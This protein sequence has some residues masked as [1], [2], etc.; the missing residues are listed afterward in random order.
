CVQKLRILIEDSDQNLK[1][2]GLLAMSKI[3]KTHP[4]SV[5]AHKDLVL[6]CLD[7][8]DESIRLRALDLLYGMIS[9]KNLMEIVRKL[10]VNIN[11]SQMGNKYRDELI[12]KIIDICS[13]NDYHFVTNFE[14]YISV[15]VEL[16]R[17][18]GGTEHGHMI[19][20]QMLD[21]AIRVESIKVFA[22]KQMAIL[23]EN[24]H[25]FGM[26]TSVSEVLYAAAWLCG[27][28]ADCLPDKRS[29]LFNLLTPSVFPPHIEAVL[30]QNASKIFSKIVKSESEDY[31]ELCA[32]I[33]TNLNPF[34]LSE[35][36][37]VQERATNFAEIVKLINENNVPSLDLESVFYAYPLNPVAS[38]AQR[39]VPVPAG[40]NLDESFQIN[41]IESDTDEDI[42]ENLEEA[43]FV[44]DDSEEEKSKYNSKKNIESESQTIAEARRLE[45]ESNPHYL[46]VKR[47]EKRDEI[48]IAEDASELNESKGNNNKVVPGLISSDKYI[49]K[50]KGKK[51]KTKK[52]ELNESDV[53][54]DESTHKV[55]IKSLEMPE[56]VDVN[57]VIID[58]EESDSISDPHKALSKITIEDPIQENPILV[59][60]KKSKKGSKKVSKVKT[61]ESVSKSK[62]KSKVKNSNIDMLIENIG[63]QH[64]EE[65]V[66]ERPQT[67]DLVEKIEKPSVAKVTKKKKKGKNKDV[68]KVTEE[69]IPS[70]KREEYEE[71][72]GSVETPLASIESETPST[73]SANFA[74]IL[75]AYSRQSLFTIAEN[76]VLQ[77]TMDSFRPNYRFM[78]ASEKTYTLCCELSLRSKS[79]SLLKNVS[80]D[81]I[82]SMGIK[83]LHSS[84][85]SFDVSSGSAKS[86]ILD[87]ELCDIISQRLRGTISYVVVNNSGSLMGNCDFKLQI[88]IS[89]FLVAAHPLRPISDIVCEL[90]DLQTLVLES[91]LELSNIVAKLSFHLHF[92]VTEQIANTAASLYATS[93]CGEMQVCLLVKRSKEEKITVEGKSNNKSL[94]QN[95]FDE[96]KQLI[97]G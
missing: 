14:W 9:K 60:E 44:K 54:N 66:K 25:L 18:E 2:L 83:I 62:V 80:L 57:D 8:K 55:T 69:E 6:A 3:L 52:T 26:N 11:E 24:S 81:W 41:G 22:T 84:E 72:V 70:R 59:V 16:S 94:L 68:V 76:D 87:I 28:F 42:E 48:D 32:M 92:K 95:V 36:L 40:L 78:G 7:D 86:L 33:L 53:E 49:K 1:Y 47:K 20:Q 39:K 85:G 31:P 37:E 27:E 77:F 75:A 34:L 19:A 51:K 93:I 82:E 10:M 5:Q 63:E 50:L 89:A 45:Q 46:K 73:P 58:E 67:L 61:K 29:V 56:G 12:A 35:D 88:P 43:L 97:N 17:V 91:A 65:S 23:L 38:V 96:I 90:T 30:I 79:V 21:V 13:Q 64:D 4:K 15:L 71:T 74:D